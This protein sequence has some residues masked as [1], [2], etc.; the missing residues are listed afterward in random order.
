MHIWTIEKW[1]RHLNYD[2]SNYRTGLR[3]RFDQKVH[4]EIKRAIKSFCKWIRSEYSFPVRVPIYVKTAKYIKAQD[5][6]MVSA[7]FLGPIDKSQE[8]YIRIASGDV[9]ELLNTLDIYTSVP[10]RDNALA[11]IL[12]LIAHE[13]THYFQWINGIELTEKGCERQAKAYVDYILD[14]YKETREHP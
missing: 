12:G 1:F 2:Q 9:S 4:P 5:G 6:E 14:E 10:Q 13:L 7:T 11:G 3:L 8:P